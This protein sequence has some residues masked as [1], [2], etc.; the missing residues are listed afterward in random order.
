MA[1]TEGESSSEMKPVFPEGYFLEKKD[2]PIEEKAKFFDRM[3]EQVRNLL[4]I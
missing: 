3:A 4:F 1:A 2:L